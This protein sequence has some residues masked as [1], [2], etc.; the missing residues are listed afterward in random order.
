[1]LS[2]GCLLKIY[3]VSQD[4]YLDLFTS[5][6]LLGRLMGQHVQHDTEEPQIRLLKEEYAVETTQTKY[7]ITDEV[8]SN[9]LQWTSNDKLGR[10]EEQVY[11]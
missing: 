1:M 5:G 4:V 3:L 8:L 10:S 9:I 6:S 11:E 7:A 2:Q